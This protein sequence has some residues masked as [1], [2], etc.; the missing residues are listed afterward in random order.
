MAGQLRRLRR[1]CWMANAVQMI[2]H[3]PP[4]SSQPMP[5]NPMIPTA[6]WA[7]LI[8]AWLD[9]VVSTLAA[10]ANQKIAGMTVP[11]SEKTASSTNP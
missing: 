6:S 9:P 10:E 11:S 4:Q 7:P 1:V 3:M 2:V 8:S 5:K